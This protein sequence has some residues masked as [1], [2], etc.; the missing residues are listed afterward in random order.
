M[1]KTYPD[2]SLERA[3]KATEGPWEASCD[4]VSVPDQVICYTHNNDEEFIAHARTDVPELARRLKRACDFL[5]FVDGTTTAINMAKELEA[6]L[7][8]K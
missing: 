5:R 6:P 2:E 7:E 3:E 4:T 8:G 1:T